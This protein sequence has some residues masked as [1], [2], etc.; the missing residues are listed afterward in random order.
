MGHCFWSRGPKLCPNRTGNTKFYKNI[1][2]VHA[3]TRF[4]WSHVCP[5]TS[6]N[7]GD[8]TEN[9]FSAFPGQLEQN[10]ENFGVLQPTTHTIYGC[11][12][13]KIEC[14]YTIFGSKS[15]V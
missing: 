9:F 2:R 4:P 1:T 13:L 3:Y 11:K 5:Q 12:T 14:C 6:R 7:K 10:L 8:F 15:A